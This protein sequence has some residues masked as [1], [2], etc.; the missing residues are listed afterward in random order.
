LIDDPDL[1][2]PGIGERDN[3][4]GLIAAVKISKRPRD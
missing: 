1:A 3:S 4:S 2:G